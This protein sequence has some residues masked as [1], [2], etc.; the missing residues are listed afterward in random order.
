METTPAEA[1]AATPAHGLTDEEISKR[2]EAARRYGEF[3]KA[4]VAYDEKYAALTQP[5]LETPEMV[6]LKEALDAAEDAY[7]EVGMSLDIIDDD[8][9]EI[10]C[11]P[12][13]DI[14]ALLGD[15]CEDCDDD[16]EGDTPTPA[17]AEAAA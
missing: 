13:T 9:G 10:A 6:A 5:I 3:F 7:C 4:E 11:L 12:G 16:A 8:T 15:D 2:R 17:P 14:P 1:P